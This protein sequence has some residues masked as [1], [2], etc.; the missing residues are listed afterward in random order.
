MEKILTISIAAYNAEKDIER[1]L[2][3]MINTSVL[4]QLDII[5][6]NDGSTD[7]TGKV[8]EKYI[9]E[10]PDSIRLI[11]KVNGGHGSTIN[12]GIRNAIG[13]Y[14]KIVDSDDWVE[15][16]G[17][18]KLVCFLSQNDVDMI[19][20]PYH[21]VSYENITCKKLFEPADSDVFIRKIYSIEQLMGNEI[22]YM[23]SLTF[24]TDC[25]RCMGPVI[26]ENCY[27]VDMEYCIFPLVYINSFVYLDFPVYDYLLGSQ[28]QSMSINN[29]VNRRNQHLKV[30]K[31]IILFYLQNRSKV[32]DKVSSVMA[33]RIKY[34]VYQQYKI[35]LCMG[36]S[37]GKEEV[38]QFDAWLRQQDDEIYEGPKGRMMKV[39]RVLRKTRFEAYALFSKVIRVTSR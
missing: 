23:H 37:D 30:T 4:E 9:R 38:K 16:D 26:D 34:A 5:V 24:K 12:E 1:C 13:K 11:N 39:I 8:V 18:E 22:L 35:F 14:F 17:L 27:Y 33:E 36:N 25:M 7:N 29:L 6:T 20:N 10:Y 3:S 31:R 2:N 19:L 21:E 32:N 15:R 28:S